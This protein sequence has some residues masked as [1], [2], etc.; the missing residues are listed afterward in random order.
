MAADMTQTKAIVDQ[1]L[2]VFLCFAYLMGCVT[3]MYL[4]QEGIEKVKFVI[5]ERRGNF[6][7]EKLISFFFFLLA[8]SNEIIHALLLLLLLYL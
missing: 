5:K 7:L 8:Y 4:K 3:A 6:Y 1:T 2:C